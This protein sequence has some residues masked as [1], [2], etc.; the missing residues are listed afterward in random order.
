MQTA[1]DQGP[2][3]APNAQ[4]PMSVQDA[5]GAAAQTV[6]PPTPPPQAAAP[7]AQ[8]Q[9]PHHNSVLSDILHAVGDVLGGPKT[10]QQVNPQTG[11]IENVPLTR[12]QRIGSGIGMYLRAAG[13]GLAQHGPGAMGKAIMAG[14][15]EEAQ[16]EQRQRENT[17]AESR[18]VQGQLLQQA[19]IAHQNNQQLL[20]QRQFELQGKE[21]QQRIND[22][23]RQFDMLAQ[24]HGFLRPQIMVDGKDINGA[25]GNEADMM[26]YFSDAAAH[27]Q[28]DGYQLMYVPTTD[29]N[30]KMS[31]TVYQ[32]PIDQM[33]KPVQVSADYFKAMT[34]LE[35]PS[36]GEVTTTYGGLIGLHSQFIESQL[37][38]AQITEAGAKTKEA[39]A[40]ANLLNQTAGGLGNSNLTGADYL[41][42]LPPNIR[43]TVQAMGEGRVG[44]S[45]LPRGKERQ[46]YVNALNRA[47]PGFDESKVQSYDSMRKD[48]ISGKTSVGI[49][50]YNT[51]I[52]H[53]GTMFDHVSGANTLSINTPGTEVHRQLELDK[54]LVSTELAKAVSNGQLTEGEQ[55]SI[56]S[57]IGGMTVNSYKERIK[58]AVTLLE[59]KLEAYQNQWNNG[60]P[61]G[62]VS[63]V[64]ILGPQAEQTITKIHGGGQPQGQAQQITATGPNGQKLMLQGGQWVPMQ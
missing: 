18:N 36:K 27:K 30:G 54:Q 43:S 9:P 5:A 33:K 46:V 17:M 59:G 11:A 37:K 26:K 10:R 52:A 31:H 22:S 61:S 19:T 50:S 51:A 13:A 45:A 3:Q 7:P 56:M 14:S 49:N 12:E 48:F 47:Y 63:P 55:K 39:N 62:M 53:L 58:E 57:K 40:Q 24:E 28:P 23:N 29:E 64:K 35:P 60:M 32:V 42:S 25:A 16:T 6:A 34:G 38:Q 20:A 21:F 8:A 1:T 4:P 41:A 15:E 2:T 44:F